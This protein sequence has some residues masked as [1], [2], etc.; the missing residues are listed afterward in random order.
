[1]FRHNFGTKKKQKKEKTMREADSKSLHTYWGG[2]QKKEQ[3]LE[4]RKKKHACGGGAGVKV[5]SKVKGEFSH[6]TKKN[7]D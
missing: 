6:G 2:Q 1:M 3:G 7:G 4:D 5:N